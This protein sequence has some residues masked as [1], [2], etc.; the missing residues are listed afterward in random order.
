MKKIIEIFKEKE[1]VVFNRLT[2]I[3]KKQELH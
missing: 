1:F 3:L 2:K